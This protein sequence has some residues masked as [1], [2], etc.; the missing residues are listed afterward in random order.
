MIVNKKKAN[1]IRLVLKSLDVK[2]EKIGSFQSSDE[3]ELLIEFK[4]SFEIDQ[5]I[6][7]LQRY[8]QEM[9]LLMPEYRRTF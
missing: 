5:L 3:D 4:D 7:L 6:H 2:F 8:K 1:K 9:S